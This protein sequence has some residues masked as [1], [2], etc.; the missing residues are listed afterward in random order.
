MCLEF[1]WSLK[2]TNVPNKFLE[3]LYSTF[4]PSTDIYWESVMCMGMYGPG[5]RNIAAKALWENH[6]WC[7]LGIGGVS[8]GVFILDM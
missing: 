6:A 3:Q 5:R 2:Q 4:F 7:V 8:V 1:A